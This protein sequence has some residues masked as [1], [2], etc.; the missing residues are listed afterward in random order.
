MQ[1]LDPKPAPTLDGSVRQ[2]QYEAFVMVDWL[3][4]VAGNPDIILRTWEEL[5]EP[6]TR[7]MLEA[8]ADAVGQPLSDVV[9]DF[10]VGSYLLHEDGYVIDS[11]VG[12]WRNRP[13]GTVGSPPE[14]PFP[15]TGEK[16]RPWPTHSDL[17]ARL[18]SLSWSSKMPAHRCA[19]VRAARPGA[20][21]RCVC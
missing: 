6:D 5:G 16:P 21:W 19:H 13:N 8:I 11:E 18:V 15:L 4:A 17:P 12:A 14:K 9:Y 2:S 7:N 10:H 1:R 20:R 3:E